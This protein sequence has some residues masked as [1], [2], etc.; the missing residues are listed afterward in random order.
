M[1]KILGLDLGTNSIGWAVVNAAVDEAGNETLLGISSAGSRIIPMSADKL[2]NFAKGNKVSQTADR[3][4]HRGERRLR[5][6]HLLRRERLLRVLNLMG[7]LP[8]HFAKE[9]NRYGKFVSNEEAKIAWKKNES[10]D[11]E[12]IFKDS[13]EKMLKEFQ[14][15]QPGLCVGEKKIPY[16]WTIYYLR[17][18]ALKEAI[19]KEELAWLLLNFNQKRGYYQLRGEDEEV[20]ENK[21]EELYSLKVVDVKNS[22]TANTEETWYDVVLENGWVYHRKSKYPLDWVG[23][24]RDFI[25]TVELDENG[26]PKKGKDGQVKRSFRNPEKDDWTLQKKKTEK[27]IDASQKYVGQYIYE[28]LLEKPS[29]KING[30]LVRT[31]ERKYYRREL[32]KILEIQ[33]KFIPELKNKDLLRQ[34]L[35]MLYSYNEG[36]RK[37]REEKGFIDFF[38]NDIIFYQ[39]PL[40]SKKSLISNC[41]Y[42]ANYF[43]LEDSKK[44]TKE[45]KKVPLKCI[46]KSHPLFQEFRLW[47]FIQNLKIYRREKEVD[48]KICFDVNVTNEFFKTTEDWVNLFDWL[49]DK[50]EIDEKSFLQYPKFGLKRNVSEY[51][52]NYVQN[53]KKYPCNELRGSILSRL[54]KLGV[55]KDFLTKERELALWEILY[56]VED[57][58]EFVKA[59]RTFAEKN[60]LDKE[61][62]I[63]EFSKFPSF[64]KDYGSYSAKAIKKLLPLMRMGKYWN[65]H[66]IDEKTRNRIEKIVTGEYDESIF[67]R[68]RDKAIHLKS[69]SDFSGLP[70]WLACYVV[71]N[72]H[73]EGEYVKWTSPADIDD[74]LAKFKQYSL[75]NPIVEQ[76]VTETLRV[77]RDI[78]KQEKQIDEIHVE[79]GREMKLP[80]KERAALTNR[81][82]EN[83][84]TNLRIK[85]ML[86][87]FKNPEYEIDGVRP[88]SLSQQDILKIYEEY[89]VSN[90]NKEDKDFEFISKISKTAQPSSSEILRYKCWLEQQYRSPYTGE[91]IPLGRLFTSDYEIEHIIPRSQY[92][93]DSFNNKVI[94]EAAVNAKKDR[95]LGCQFIKE[96]GGEIVELGNGKTVRILTFDDYKEFVEKH[97]SA[98]RR[99]R[100]NLLREELPETF[101]QQQL[102]DTRYISK[103]VQG[104]LSNIVRE[105][106]ESEATSKHLIPCN[107]KVTDWLKKDWGL[108]DVWNEII[109]PRFIRMN[110]IWNC[111][112]YTSRNASGNEIPAVP[113]ECQKGFNKK[114][115]DHRHHAMDAIVIACANRNI[116]NYLNNV[117][118]NEM[119]T[120]YDLRKILC[121]KTR[122]DAYGNYQWKFKKPWETFTQDVKEKLKGIIVSFKQNLR[123]INK[124]VNRYESYKD[125]DGNLR[126]DKNGVPKKGF[127][128]QKKGDRWAVRKSLHKATFFGEVNL[129]KEKTVALGQAMKNS[130][131]IVDKKFRAQL[132]IFISQGKNPKWIRAYFEENKKDWP[133]LDLSKILVRYY[134]KETNE[135]YFATRFMSE[136]VDFFKGEKTEEKAL[137]RIGEITDTGIQKILRNHLANKNGNA[138]LAFSA[139]GI[140]E[141]NRNI[142]S[143][144]GGKFHYPIYKVRRFEKANKYVIGNKGSKRKKF[145]EADKGTN[146]FFAVYADEN[147]KRSYDSVPLNVV[148]ERHKQKKSSVPEVNEKGNKLLFSLSPNDL[149]SLIDENTGKRSIY[150]MVSSSE[151][152]CYFVPNSEASPIVDKKEFS[153]LNKM[154][155]S[156]DGVMIKEKCEPLKVDR[157]GNIIGESDM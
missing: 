55:E 35:E 60:N 95:S 14:R 96:S 45:L 59:L 12:F 81:I 155:R 13:F 125:E 153:P 78:W 29:Q 119:I 21:T 31:I 140:E 135:R 46:A 100:E 4:F 131:R 30:K 20:K 122:P 146:L 34:C 123:V 70:V 2:G 105:S 66:A 150:K 97:Y 38:V 7:F 84:T 93:D 8:E 132:Q 130:S 137:A 33:S 104:L 145:V 139:D 40:K 50:K 68:V 67:N 141:M 110:H 15:R 111:D 69:A 116:V 36:H 142:V 101:T 134:T 53:D 17:A 51:R 18:H 118:G 151:G 27:E 85:K 10:G 48:G 89:A 56:S 136:L 22:V 58:T 108:H 75:R 147:G 6:R 23:K 157:L 143:L 74:Y 113:I 92:N 77:V 98:N 128:R 37:I 16:D 61:T 124:T 76:V 115:I 144:N 39:R 54:S 99:K 102:N 62:F 129:Q 72:R 87:E 25:V 41:P 5:E 49:N 94:C 82:L 63:G 103:F 80:A 107:G 71:Y 47:Q 88:Y 11:Y 83:E 117:S 79:L 57:K 65:E 9:I 127:I 91:I 120:R 152:A 1:K 19:S 149:V 42:E 28:T 26:E 64:P 148:I 52:W 44:K 3:T 24:I 126:L 43:V 156:I 106:D 133:D 109:L 154:E 90:I 138:E 32:E 114:R 73:S 112:C 121:Y 86:M